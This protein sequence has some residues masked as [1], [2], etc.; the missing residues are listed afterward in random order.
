MYCRLYSPLEGAL[1]VVYSPLEGALPVVYSPL[2]GALPVVYSTLEG[3]LPVVYS[4][5]EGALP[6]VYSTLEGALP[7]V[8]STL[9]GA[10]PVVYST[11]EGALPVVYSTLEGALPVVYST[12]EG[13]L[14]V[15]CIRRTPLAVSMDDPSASPVRGMLRTGCSFEDDLKLGAE[16]NHLQQS[17]GAE[18]DPLWYVLDKRSHYKARQRSINSTG[19]G[20]S[21]TVSSVSELLDLY[22]EDPEEV[23]LNLGFGREEPDLAS[24]VPC[25]FLN[26]TSGARGIDITV[27]LGAQLQRLELENPNY[28]LTSR[29][30][31]IEVLTTV[32]NE[33]F[34]LY[35]QEVREEEKEARCMET[36]S[37]ETVSE[38]TVSEET[39]QTDSADRPPD[40]SPEHHLGSRANGDTAVL[41]GTNPQERSVG[42]PLEEG[43]DRT[44][45]PDKLV[46]LTPLL[47]LLAQ[48]KDYPKDSFEMDEV[49]STDDDHLLPTSQASDLLRSASQQ[50]DSSGFAEDPSSYSANFLK[51]QDSSDSCD[52]E[53]TVTSH[54][55]ATPLAQDQPAFDLLSD[56]EDDGRGRSVDIPQYSVHH[57]HRTEAVGTNLPHDQDWTQEEP[58]STAGPG[59]VVDGSSQTHMLDDPSSL[60]TGPGSQI[61]D[62]GSQI[63]EAGS[64]VPSPTVLKS[65]SLLIRQALNRAK[66]SRPLPRTSPSPACW[67]PVQTSGGGRA[68]DRRAP[69]ERSSSLPCSLLAPTK[70]VSSVRI[71]FGR[72]DPTTCTS[73]RFSFQYRCGE[74]EEEEERRENKVHSDG[75][76]EKCLSTLIINPATS[77]ANNPSQKFR[78]EPP[79]VQHSRLP[80]S[81]SPLPQWSERPP[82]SQS[83]SWSTQSVPNF[84]SN[85]QHDGLNQYPY[86]NLNRACSS[87]PLYPH[88]TA[89][90]HPATVPHHTSM[91]LPPTVPHHTSMHLPPTVPHHT[92]MHLPPTACTPPSPSHEHA[93]SSHSPP[94]HE[95]AS[96]H[97]PHTSAST[98]HHTA[99]Y[100]PTS[101]TMPQHAG[102][103][104]SHHGSVCSL[105]VTPVTRY[106]DCSH[107]EHAHPSPV[108]YLPPLHTYYGYS[109]FPGQ[110]YLLSPQPRPASAPG[111]FHPGLAPTPEQMFHPGLAPTPGQMVHPGLAPTPGQMVHPG[112]APTPGQMFHPGLAPTPGQMF[113]P[114]L[115]PTPGQMFHPGLAPT[116]GQMFHPGLA[117][118]PGQMFHPGLA[119]TPEQLLLQ[120][121]LDYVDRASSPGPSFSRSSSPIRY[122]SSINLVP[123]PPTRAA[124]TDGQARGKRDGRGESEK[125]EQENGEERERGGREIEGGGRE[126]ERGGREIEGGGREIERGGREIEGGGREI[127]RGGREERGDAALIISSD[128]L[129][130]IIEEDPS[131]RPTLGVSLPPEDS[132]V[133]TYFTHFHLSTTTRPNLAELLFIP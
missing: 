99:M 126:I 35:S 71:Q 62:T 80:P 122:R 12:L 51:V 25:R 24:K 101:P 45:T 64:L 19:S 115:A 33:F 76:L 54:D 53:N 66:P 17:S 22:E 77:D 111:Q 97:V 40:T 6:V 60:V 68:G 73:P 14:P 84:S 1:P 132:A 59:P 117:P 44:S 31:Q 36:V 57:F 61:S 55:A 129:Q 11:L 102:L 124:S 81:S 130:H 94:S 79:L 83:L 123:A 86:R 18:A 107:P 58:C 100:L 50:S 67:V 37:E 8:Y 49:Q 105:P 41:E 78:C 34:Q 91:H 23:L 27:Y 52:S 16:A 88:H 63:S 110:P 4:T 95:H 74:G 15:V 85:Q 30:R 32:A 119:P 114:G 9:E 98:P 21:S 70:V 108:Q 87:T 121:E 10:L 75:G 112:L 69:L 90:Q 7:V 127:E 113:H 72:E 43:R 131:W 65:P 116:P 125:T 109:P 128:N 26:N 42:R 2:E 56:R 29:F 39:D 46:S 20:K 28:A 89:M 13:A 133:G 47:P 3:A 106:Q 82:G 118:T 104:M 96:L 92:S 120:S 48:L 5:L 103:Q 93:S 38:E